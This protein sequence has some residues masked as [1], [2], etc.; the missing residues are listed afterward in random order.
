MKDLLKK[1]TTQILNTTPESEIEGS[2]IF[3]S[4]RETPF[5][6]WLYPNHLENWWGPIIGVAKILGSIAILIPGFP[7]IA[8]WA[9]AGLMFDL[10]GATY[11]QVA[12]IG[13]QTPM[14]FMILPFTFAILSHWLYHRKL[15][16]SN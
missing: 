8:E 12:V 14:L 10:I 7:R 13:F 3:N 9:Y 15:Q 5:L 16:L 6:A 2:R 4:G 11:S 1:M